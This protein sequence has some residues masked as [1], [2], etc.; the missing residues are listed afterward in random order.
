VEKA[1]NALEKRPS[2]KRDATFKGIRPL[3]A[4]ERIRNQ[5]FQRVGGGAGGDSQETEVKKK[6]SVEGIGGK[7]KVGG[8]RKKGNTWGKA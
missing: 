7:K 8:P 6:N 2:Q 5:G 1:R 4:G 3:G